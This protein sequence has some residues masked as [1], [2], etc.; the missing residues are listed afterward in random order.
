MKQNLVKKLSKTIDQSNIQLPPVWTSS[1]VV[2]DKV[3]AEN[4]HGLFV[5]GKKRA[6]ASYIIDLINEAKDSVVITS[7]LL[8]DATLED[9]IFSA[10]ERGV[11]VYI[12]LACETRL[13]PDTPDDD[14]G[15]ECLEQHQRMLKRLGG[16]VMIRSASHYHSKIVIVDALKH[17]ADSDARGILL[18]ANLTKEAFERNEELAVVLT[19][20]EIVETIQVLKWAMFEYAE[21]EMLNNRDFAA[22]K[23]QSVVSF[24]Q[25]L[26]SVV[27][28][29]NEHSGIKNKLLSLINESSQKLIISSFGWQEDHEV[30]DAICDKAKQGVEVTILSRVRPACMSALIKLAE[31]GANIY[32]FR[33]LHAKAVWNEQNHG[34]VMSA[35]LEQHGLDEGFEIGLLLTGSRAELLQECLDGLLQNKASTI[36]QLFLRSKLKEHQGEI[37]YWQGK[38][39]KSI[40]VTNAITHEVKSIQADCLTQM[41]L[42]PALPKTTWKENPANAIKYTWEVIPPVLPTNSKEVTWE[43]KVQLPPKDNEETTSQ[44][45]R[46]KNNK[47]NKNNKN[48]KIIKHSYEPQVYQS[49]KDTLIAITDNTKLEMATRLRAETFPQAKIVL[50]S[51]G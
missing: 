8:A 18:T 11:R 40:S 35:N 32:G 6:M 23:K 21:H 26:K 46:R 17:P 3:I 22:I 19:P 1:T 44:K 16:K 12:M 33:W 10:S 27:V 28:T 25:E 9:A 36:S 4:H 2:N 14:F 20:E 30:I 48:V 39:L 15:K 45:K 43:E 13:E 34:M 7:F 37:S 47:N 31:A 38:T 5:S 50:K 41:D 42:E 49:G 29:T 51:G 24:P